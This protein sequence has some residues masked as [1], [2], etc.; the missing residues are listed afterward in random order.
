MIDAGPILQDD[1]STRHGHNGMVN[2][3]SVLV[4][5]FFVGICPG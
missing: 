2:M 4:K 1:G 3:R 5:R